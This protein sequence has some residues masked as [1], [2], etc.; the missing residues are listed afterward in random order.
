MKRTRFAKTQIVSIL[1]LHKIGRIFLDICRGHTI[2][3]ESFIHSKNKYRGMVVCDVKR[4][5]EFMEK[6]FRFKWMLANLSLVHS[7]LKDLISK[8]AR[9]PRS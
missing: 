7:I 9:H 4:L 1:N 8:K 6:N 3:E 5:K 2:A